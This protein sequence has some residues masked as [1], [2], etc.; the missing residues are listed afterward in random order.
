MNS[1]CHLQKL[2]LNNKKITII[3]LPKLNLNNKKM[4]IVLYSDSK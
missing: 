2:N 4:T 1:T 3:H